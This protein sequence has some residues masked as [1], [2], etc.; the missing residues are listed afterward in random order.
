MRKILFS[1]LFLSTAVSAEV[2]NGT[3]SGFNLG[4]LNTKAE[5]TAITDSSTS[6][7]KSFS[8]GQMTAGLQ[9]GYAATFSNNMYAAADLNVNIDFFGTKRHPWSYNSAATTRNAHVKTYRD[10]EIALGGRL[11]YNFGDFVV[12]AGPFIGF[13]KFTY[14]Y[15]DQNDNKSNDPFKLVYGPLIGGDYKMTDKLTAGIEFRY[16]LAGATRVSSTH[17]S[18]G[19]RKFKPTTFD[20]RMRINFA[21]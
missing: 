9:A 7:K 15:T 18:A 21:F 2:F 14:K 12:Y 17:F 11:G 20:T 6:S 1:A 16:G 4:Y 19:S 5:V 3:F 8:A 13:A 10:Y